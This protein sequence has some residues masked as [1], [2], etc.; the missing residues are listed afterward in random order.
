MGKTGFAVATTLLVV[1]SNTASPHLPPPSLTLLQILPLMF[2]IAREEQVIEAEK[3]QVKELKAQGVMDQQLV[4]M[5]L[6]DTLHAPKV[7]L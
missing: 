3:L 7:L 2:E 6:G 4:Q 5:G 1:V